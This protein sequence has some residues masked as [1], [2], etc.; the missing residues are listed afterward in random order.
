MN[1]F[2]STKNKKVPSLTF[3]KFWYQNYVNIITVRRRQGF[4]IIFE[5][6]CREIC[7]LEEVYE[8][9][10]IFTFLIFFRVEILFLE[11]LVSTDLLLDSCLFVTI[12]SEW[13]E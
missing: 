11:N 7:C 12:V 6:K 3:T 10:S 9:K 2:F 4:A 1:G 13:S 5:K 8:F